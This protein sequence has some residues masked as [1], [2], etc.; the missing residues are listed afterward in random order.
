[1]W[2]GTPD[3]LDCIVKVETRDPASRLPAE[4]WVFLVFPYKTGIESRKSATV[5]RTN[6]GKVIR[7]F[8][9]I[10]RVTFPMAGNFLE[11]TLVVLQVNYWKKVGFPIQK[12]VFGNKE[13]RTDSLA[14]KLHVEIKYLYQEY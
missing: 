9:Y 12:A 2:V 13:G 10:E 8:M 5:H 4:S 3:T 7:Q 1:M 6:V 14:C 11:P